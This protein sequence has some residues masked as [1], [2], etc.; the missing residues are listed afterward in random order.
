M[1]YITD[2]KLKSWLLHQRRIVLLAA[3]ILNF[4]CVIKNPNPEDCQIITT[5]ITT[6]FEGPSCDIVFKDSSGDFY[7]INRGLDRDLNI[8]SL[9]QS[10]L[11]KSVTL[12]L[13]KFVIGTSEHIAQLSIEDKVLFAE[14]K[15]N[16]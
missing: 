12:H 3:I 8:E 1:P 6:V 4:S 9:K 16:N 13:S 11:N 7:Y 10:V 2:L 5:E 14:F 15:N